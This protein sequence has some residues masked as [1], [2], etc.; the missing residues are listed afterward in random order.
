MNY[1]AQE[2]SRCMEAGL[3]MQH[4]RQ[5]RARKGHRN[6]HGE[7]TL[8]YDMEEAIKMKQG[9]AERNSFVNRDVFWATWSHHE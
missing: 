9:V 3:T 5:E 7:K 8:K 4:R 6:Y 2:L 1:F